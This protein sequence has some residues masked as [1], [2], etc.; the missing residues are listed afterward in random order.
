[1]T[2][3]ILYILYIYI[4]T[5]IIYI[6]Y[7][8]IY[9]YTHTHIYSHYTHSHIHKSCPFCDTTNQE[10]FQSAAFLLTLGMH[11]SADDHFSRFLQKGCSLLE[12]VT[13]LVGSFQ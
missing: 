10:L 3:Y 1:M 7:I 8:C 11:E 6:I 12:T 13:M 5:Y 2:K 9:I 4:Y